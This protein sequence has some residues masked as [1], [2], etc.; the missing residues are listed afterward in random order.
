MHS[1]KRA[2]R[3]RL[4]R[5]SHRERFDKV[6][7]ILLYQLVNGYYFLL[8]PF[9]LFK[10]TILLTRS[11]NSWRVNLSVFNP[12]SWIASASFFCCSTVITFLHCFRNLISTENSIPFYWFVSSH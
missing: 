9:R 8:G 11:L 6:H 4:V 7:I 1:M 3:S 2:G 12:P 10:S 5:R